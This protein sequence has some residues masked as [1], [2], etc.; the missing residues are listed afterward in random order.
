MMRT[1]VLAKKV[2]MTRVFTEAGRHVPVTVLQ[3]DNCQVTAVRT[4]DKDGYTAVQLGA[5]KAKAKNV[6]KAQRGHFGKAKV[7]PKQKLGEFRVSEDALLQPGQELSA[8]HFVP[9]Q[10][11]DAS[12][13]T[14]GRGF[15]GVMKRHNFAGLRATHGVSAVHRSQGST[16]QMQDP[17]KVFKGKKMHGH[18]GQRK[19]T[20]QSLQVVSV[21]GERNLILVRGNIPGADGSWVRVADAIKRTLPENV[22]FPA[23][24]RGTAESEVSAEQ[25]PLAETAEE[26]EGDQGATVGDESGAEAGG[27]EKKDE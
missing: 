24:L 14:I 21:D 8:T 11:V 23:G 7:P 12:G 4:Q 6:S 17:G 26:L 2:G 1:G 20:T 25:D 13:I 18:M 27:E 22:P 10:Y 9:G 19:V 3:V 16:G 5:G 15:A